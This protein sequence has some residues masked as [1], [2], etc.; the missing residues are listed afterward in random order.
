MVPKIFVFFVQHNLA[1][2]RVAD[3]THPEIIA[4]D[5]DGRPAKIGK[6][7]HVALEPGVLHHI[8][9]GF[10]VRILAVRKRGDKQIYRDDFPCFLV[11]QRHRGSAPVHFT[12][13]ARFVEKMTGQAV[14]GHIVRISFA[15]LGIAEG[16]GLVLETGVLVFIPQK[17]Q[18]D[19]GLLELG[20]DIVVVRNLVETFFSMLIRVKHPVGFL[21]G[22]VPDVIIRYAEPVGNPADVAYRVLG[23]LSRSTDLAL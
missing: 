20:M 17:F 10:H 6:H 22:L 9:A 14:F 3:N 12:D 4:L 16:D 1:F 21:I 8:E 7:V 2:A 13:D 23:H 15:E 19:P 11:N 5:A 18:I